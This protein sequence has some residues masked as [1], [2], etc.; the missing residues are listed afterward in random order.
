MSL[1]ITLSYLVD[2]NG[3]PIVF[4]EWLDTNTINGYTKEEALRIHNSSFIESMNALL[5]HNIMTPGDEIAICTDENEIFWRFF[6]SIPYTED[7]EV[8]PG[9]PNAPGL[10]DAL[11][12]YQLVTREFCRTFTSIEVVR[13]VNGVVTETLTEFGFITQESSP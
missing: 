5:E 12:A 6:K 9:T 8:V 7:S 2:S 13:T 11:N 3:F 10:V 4:E 1:N